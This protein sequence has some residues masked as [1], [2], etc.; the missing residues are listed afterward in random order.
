MAKVRRLLTIV[1]DKCAQCPS[2]EY[3]CDRERP[4][5]E[6]DIFLCLKTDPPREIPGSLYS[7]PEWCPRE[8]PK[9]EL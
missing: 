1:I 3:R 6:Q 4:L 7:I 2:N 5:M 8:A 9:E